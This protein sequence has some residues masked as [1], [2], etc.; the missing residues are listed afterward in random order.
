MSH[1]ENGEGSVFT[2]SDNTPRVLASVDIPA[3]AP[4]LR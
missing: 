1:D 3:R 2:D 4:A